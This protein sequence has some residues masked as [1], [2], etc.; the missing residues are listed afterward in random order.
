MLEASECGTALKYSYTRD[1]AM[2]GNFRGGIIVE[3]ALACAHVSWNY[4]YPQSTKSTPLAYAFVFT[5]YIPP[6]DTARQRGTYHHCT[7]LGLL[8]H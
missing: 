7:H 6:I 3:Q 4:A 1:D 2:A 5:F 8:C